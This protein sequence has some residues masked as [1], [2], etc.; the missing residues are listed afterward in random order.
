MRF[1]PTVRWILTA[2][3]ALVVLGAAAGA[4]PA[5]RVA[6]DAAVVDAMA[7]AAK[8]PDLSVARVSGQS[9]LPF[10]GDDA[11]IV[12][13]KIDAARL[14]VGMIAIYVN[15]FG[16]KIAHRVIAQ[17]DGGWQMQGYSNDEPD[18]TV[19]NNTNLLGIVYATFLSAGRQP[20]MVAAADFPVIQTVYAAPAK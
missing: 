6:Y 4:R 15:R 11:V 9:M 8:R 3:A 19:V 14:R 16:E 10:F 7:V 12:M 5:S 1:T 18:S 20:V 2:S 17:V 13:K